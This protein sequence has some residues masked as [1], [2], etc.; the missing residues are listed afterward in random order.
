MALEIY[1]L[2]ISQMVQTPEWDGPLDPSKQ[3]TAGMWW[4][5]DCQDTVF[6]NRR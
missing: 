6:H 5:A 1:S 3:D 4:I 2:K